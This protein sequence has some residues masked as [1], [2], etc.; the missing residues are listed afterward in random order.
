MR[1]M[2]A[3][4]PLKTVHK[5]LDEGRIAPPA[6]YLSR[7]QVE[8]ELEEIRRTGVAMNK[9]RTTPEEFGVAAVVRDLRG[10]ATGCV[11]LSAPSSRVELNDS[12]AS[13]QEAVRQTANDISTRLGA[14][15]SENESR[16]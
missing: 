13:F 9:S 5:L 7:K 8:A 4:E 16:A 1:V 6:E 15:V 12:A 14:L 3:Y 2:L 10:A 11:I